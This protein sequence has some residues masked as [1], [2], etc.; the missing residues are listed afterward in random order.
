M[1][2]LLSA[3]EGYRAEA[4]PELPDARIEEDFAELHRAAELIELER[5]RRLAEIDR[6]KLFEPRRAPVGG[7]VAHLGASASWGSAR[8][9]TRTARALDEMPLTRREIESGEV[10]L[11]AA[12]VLVA[13]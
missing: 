11:A 7:I 9:A 6:R 12:R 1:S 8:A 4:L 2:G 3:I 10:S 5:L 13:A